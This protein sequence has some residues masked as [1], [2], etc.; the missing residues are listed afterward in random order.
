MYEAMGIKVVRGI[1]RPM[2]VY[3]RREIQLSDSSKTRL[4]VS[5]RLPIPNPYSPSPCP[6]NPSRLRRQSE[7]VT[8]EK[9]STTHAFRKSKVKD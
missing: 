4:L 3:S 1:L 5:L 2:R 9:D 6:R 7:P 8:P